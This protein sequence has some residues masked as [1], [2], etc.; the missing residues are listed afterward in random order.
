MKFYKNNVLSSS[1]WKMHAILQQ[2]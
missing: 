2:K 1:S